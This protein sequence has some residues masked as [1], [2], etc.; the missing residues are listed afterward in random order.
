MRKGVEGFLTGSCLWRSAVGPG[1]CWRQGDTD[2]KNWHNVSILFMRGLTWIW[3]T[4]G[5]YGDRRPTG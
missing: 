3:D 1:C 4:A 5:E 2:G